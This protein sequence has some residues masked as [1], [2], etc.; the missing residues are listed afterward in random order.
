MQSTLP[1][2]KKKYNKNVSE[3]GV[4]GLK[5]NQTTVNSIKVLLVF[6]HFSCFFC[7]TR[8]RVN[9][10]LIRRMV[11]KRQKPTLKPLF[12]PLSLIQ[13]SHLAASQ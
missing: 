8:R 3:G 12:W 5:R 13:V 1:G 10:L 6:V 2:N 7:L 11:H 9:R 4:A